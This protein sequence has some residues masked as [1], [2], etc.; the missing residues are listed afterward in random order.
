MDNINAHEPFSCFLSLSL[1]LWLK[2]IQ[3]KYYRVKLKKH[4]FIQMHIIMFCNAFS[5]MYCDNNLLTINLSIKYVPRWVFF[6]NMQNQHV[7]SFD[8]PPSRKV[9]HFL[10]SNSL[11]IW[12]WCWKNAE[13]YNLLGFKVNFNILYIWFIPSASWGLWL[14]S[15]MEVNLFHGTKPNNSEDML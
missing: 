3:N 12:C 1:F 11:K 15:R 9:G 13:R 14:L 6:L 5:W 4:Q 8:R 7:E 10:L 2:H